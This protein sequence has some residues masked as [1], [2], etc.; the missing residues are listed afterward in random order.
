MTCTHQP[1]DG[2]SKIS[3]PGTDNNANGF[4]STQPVP[5]SKN[6]VAAVLVQ[7]F[8][9]LAPSREALR[10]SSRKSRKQRSYSRIA[11]TT[12]S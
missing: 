5:T 9:D 2:C 12:M 6:S 8:V 4:E 11:A 1:C 10:V 7:T 3:Q